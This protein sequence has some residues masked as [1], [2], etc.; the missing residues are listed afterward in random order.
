MGETGESYL[1]GPDSLMRSDSY[2]DAE[3]RNVVSA[4]RNP[5][6][7]RVKTASTA[8][9]LAGES[10]LEVID[11]YLGT[12]VVSAYAPV[13]IA[14]G[15]TWAI[16]SE[17]E[18]SEAYA[19]RAALVS[20]SAAER[21]GMMLALGTVV[22]VALFALLITGGGLGML[23]SRPALRAVQVAEN[24]AAGD[25]DNE[26]DATSKDEFGQLLGALDLMQAN[27]KERIEREARNA[28]DMRIKQAL[29]YVGASVTMVAPDGRIVYLNLAAEQMFKR[30]ADAIRRE[31]PVFDP[32]AMVQGS[33]DRMF[34]GKGLG[35]LIREG[36]GQQTRHVTLGDRRFDVRS[37]SVVGPDGEFLGAALQWSDRTEE[38]AV[39]EEINAVVAA[40][41]EGEFHERV[42][43]DGKDGFFLRL[44]EGFNRILSTSE[45][46]LNDVSRVLK[47]IAEGDLTRRIEADYKGIFLE[48]KQDVNA[49]IARL[50]QVLGDIRSGA[51]QLSTLAGTVNETAQSMRSGAN[52]QAS[53]IEETSAA[54]V[55]MSASISQNSDNAKV[56]DG[57]AGESAQSASQG[58]D[59][60]S[61][62]VRAMKQIAEQIGII[63]DIASQTN[64]LA[65]N[66]AIEAA[67]A[68]HHGK[69]FA[70]VAAEVRK[71]AER[72]AAAASDIGELAAESVEVAE[73][74]GRLLQEMVPRI[75]RTAD[76][77]QEITAAS[78]E[79]AIG[80][81]EIE[82]AIS[83][84]DGVAQQTSI[85]A[86]Q[87]AGTA[88]DLQGH[89][90]AMEQRVSF[91]QLPG[92]SPSRPAPV[93]RPPAQGQ[94]QPADDDF[95]DFLP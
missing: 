95:V 74:A 92:G 57:I 67:R 5:E 2:R 50:G 94:Q 77:V 63:E 65:L 17:I 26:I 88:Q 84:L 56:T 46:G 83:Q 80:A 20:S 47:A 52:T 12:Q 32:D 10:G 62:T 43:L 30:R 64:L 60:V 89:S 93:R 44:A 16:V 41:A 58:G 59:A 53:S 42:A 73:D 31:F 39:E 79:Q 8:A 33:V 85:A 29:D 34:G 82:N 61:R 24:I 87:L 28:D 15:V 22:A 45:A 71:L 36:A 11:G 14:E 90:A 35:D 78:S 37:N 91:F 9:A 23:F 70:V 55:E 19:T 6:Q 13:E 66:A 38:L 81:G 68:G 7:G 27:L 49:S 40:A 21:R 75:R 86:Q 25:L 72:S 4:F 3:N 69:G 48:L 76:L 54:M 1:V 51:E 18:A